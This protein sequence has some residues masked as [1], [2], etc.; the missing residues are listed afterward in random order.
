MWLLLHTKQCVCPVEPII[1]EYE[2]NNYGNPGVMRNT[3]THSVEKVWNFESRS[4]W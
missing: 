4:R 3:W 2:N 1:A